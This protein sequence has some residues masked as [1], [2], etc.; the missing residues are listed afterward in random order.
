MYNFSCV[1]SVYHV[2]GKKLMKIDKIY[3]FQ[4][5][6][7]GRLGCRTFSKIFKLT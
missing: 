1:F 3:V 4:S 5:S 2:K 6:S 7:Q